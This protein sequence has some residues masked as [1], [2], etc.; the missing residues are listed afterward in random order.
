MESP[1]SQLLT[2]VQDS[3]INIFGNLSVEDKRLTLI[4]SQ[5]IFTNGTLEMNN[6]TVLLIESDTRRLEDW[7]IISNQ[8]LTLQGTLL[9]NLTTSL[10]GTYVINIAKS[11]QNVSLSLTDTRVV[12]PPGSC[13]SDMQQSTA[14]GAY[15]LQVTV[16]YD[17]DCEEVARTLAPWQI[18]LIAAG[19]VVVIVGGLVGYML[20]K[21]SERKRRNSQTMARISMTA[22]AGLV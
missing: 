3:T 5:I 19:S 22:A 7:S 13:V 20:K 8:Q 12:S 16:Q 17:N 11:T 1:A 9:V 4:D 14:A 21:R 10:A 15:R 18:G 6:G 2:I